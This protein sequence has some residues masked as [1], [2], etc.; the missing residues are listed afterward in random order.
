MPELQRT[1]TVPETRCGHI[2]D[3]G[4]LAGQDAACCWRPVH[5]NSDRCFWHLNGE[6]SATAFAA[7][8]PIPG[9]RLDGANF[10]NADL[11]DATWLRG[12][13]LI[14]ADFTGA[15][16]RG[17]D[18]SGGD[19][20]QATFDSVDARRTRFDQANLENAAFVDADLRDASLARTKLY[21]TSFTNI[22]LNRASDFG[23]SVIYEEL[24]TDTTD[25]ETRVAALE[26]TSWTYHELRRLFERD[27]L[28]RRARACY[29]G[30]KS[31]RRR[32]AWAR[33][34]YFH[35]LKL[36]GSRWVMRYGTSPT[37][38]I[39]SSVGVIVGCAVLYPLMGGLRAPIAGVYGLEN[40]ATELLTASPEHLA[41]LFFKGLYFSVVTFATLGYGDMQPIGTWARALAG[42]ESLLGSLLMAL[43]VFVLTRRA[44]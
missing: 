20:R 35:A 18:L 9:E 23:E 15:T 31:A 24:V 29:L 12:C 14:G 11:T 27:A 8:H 39:T 17:A 16:L 32:T 25:C 1:S 43:L 37:R 42:I 36:E 38:V 26:A 30:E 10:R 40:P 41:L 28:P 19:F 6:R 13:S 44:P 4:P 3:V 21:R 5:D 2:K 34:E 22:R 33:N 7:H